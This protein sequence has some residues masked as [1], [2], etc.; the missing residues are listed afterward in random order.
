MVESTPTELTGVELIHAAEVASYT[1]GR[2][3]RRG[4]IAASSRE[5]ESQRYARAS[6]E[7]EGDG[8]GGK[9]LR[10]ALAVVVVVAATLAT[11][12]SAA[13]PTG[14]PGL[15]LTEIERFTALT[16]PNYFLGVAQDFQDTATCTVSRRGVFL[17][18]V[19]HRGRIFG[20]VY[21][22]TRTVFKTDPLMFK[23]G[24]LMSG[25]HGGCYA[26]RMTTTEAAKYL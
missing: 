1:P 15:T 2:R 6:R 23:D 22:C 24:Y 18:A 21:N 16:A 19:N 11:V 14:V 3:S 9:V 20:V 26:R 25:L 17:C 8:H 10:L 12:A 5:P 4:P 7:A 13:I